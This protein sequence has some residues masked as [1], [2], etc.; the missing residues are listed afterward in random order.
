VLLHAWKEDKNYRILIPDSVFYGINGLTHD[1]VRISFKTRAER[2]FG[3]L[4]LNVNQVKQPGQYIIQV[5]NE[6]ETAVY[7]ERIINAPGK[8]HF[9][10]L[11]ALKYQ[12][13]AIY[14]R[15]GNGHWDTGKYKIHLQPEEVIYLPKIVE[16]RA[17]WDIEETLD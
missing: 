2:D 6:K 3:N 4:V 10:Y 1:T 12:V 13:K 17:N 14:D 11:P 5:M 9:N 15:N 16:I 7:E 8:V